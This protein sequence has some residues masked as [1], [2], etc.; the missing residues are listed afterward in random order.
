MFKKGMIALN[1][2]LSAALLYTGSKT[3]E[4]NIAIPEYPKTQTNLHPIRKDIREKI[5]SSLHQ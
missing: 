3:Y 1:F 5:S 2:G 4:T